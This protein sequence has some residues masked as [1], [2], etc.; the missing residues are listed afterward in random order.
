[1]NE[2]FGEQSGGDIRARDVAAIAGVVA[3]GTGL[4][5]SYMAFEYNPP[6]P[7]Y[8]NNEAPARLVPDKKAK[9]ISESM[10]SEDKDPSLLL[11]QTLSDGRTV[12][13]RKPVFSG[14]VAIHEPGDKVVPKDLEPPLPEQPYKP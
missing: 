3:V 1:M 12:T 13:I 2:R 11:R 6:R 4:W 5:V 7:N 10:G 9:I 8:G 14:E